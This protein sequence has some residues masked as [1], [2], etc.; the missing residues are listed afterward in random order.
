MG[1]E[2]KLRKAIS[3][4][5]SVNLTAPELGYFTNTVNA[6]ENIEKV[7]RT[8][9]WKAI[10]DILDNANKL[11]A[12]YL[13]Y[14]KENMS[15]FYFKIWE[16]VLNWSVKNVSVKDLQKMNEYMSKTSV[17]VTEEDFQIFEK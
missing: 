16:I 14:G 6:V 7:Y 10:M 13:A 4:L 2:A 11:S 8:K 3:K 9:S 17:D 12:V 5:D 1:I 15:K